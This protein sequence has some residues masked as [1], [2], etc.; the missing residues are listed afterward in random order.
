MMSAQAHIQ[1][2]KVDTPST[3]A[4]FKDMH[5]GETIIVCGCGKSLNLLENPERF[6]TIGVNDVGRRFHPN[7][8]VVVNPCSQFSG[9]RLRYVETARALSFQSIR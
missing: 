2:R 3:L 1:Q 4:S 8:L 6:V 9:D 7:Y 5:K